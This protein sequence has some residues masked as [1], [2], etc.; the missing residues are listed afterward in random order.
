MGTQFDKPDENGRA[1]ADQ[2]SAAEQT[3][4]ASRQPYR[5]LRTSAAPQEQE[6]LILDAAEQEFAEVGV[7]RANME[8][9]ARAAGVSRSTLY[10]RFANKELLLAEVFKRMQATLRNRLIELESGWNLSESVVNGFVETVRYMRTN[11]MLRRMFEREPEFAQVLMGFSG[12]AEATTL[13]E[14][15]A[16]VAQA[17]VR[18]GAKMPERDLLTAAEVMCRIIASVIPTGASFVDIDDD[19]QAREFAQKFLVPLVW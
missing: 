9:V 5:S 17:L 14:D 7:R 12:S 11:A 10:R 2:L 16:A 6:Q 19:A 4:A 15:A 13:R 1:A 18:A 8:E 3:R